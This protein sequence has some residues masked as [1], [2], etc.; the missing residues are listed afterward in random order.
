MQFHIFRQRLVGFDKAGNGRWIV[1]FPSWAKRLLMLCTVITMMNSLLALPMTTAL[2]TGHEIGV[3]SAWE[4][5]RSFFAG[6]SIFS[7]R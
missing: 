2:P 3:Y 4:V 5:G 1:G 7:S 6:K